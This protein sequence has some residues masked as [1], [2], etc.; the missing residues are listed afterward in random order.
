MKMDITGRDLGGYVE[1]YKG[2]R[3]E[4]KTEQV[5]VGEKAHYRVLLGDRLAAGACRRRVA[6]R[7]QRGRPGAGAGAR[8][9][10]S[11]VVGRGAGG[12]N[13]PGVI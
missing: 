1:A 2:Y 7:A 9:G 4:V 13:Q 8:G 3:L 10:G 6:Q 11:G 5:W 12:L